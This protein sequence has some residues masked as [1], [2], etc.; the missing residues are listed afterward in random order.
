MQIRKS[1]P[2]DNGAAKDLVRISL[3]IFG[4][5]ADFDNLDKAIGLLGT[6]DSENSIELVAVLDGVVVGCLAIQRITPQCAR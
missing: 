4:I 6:I 2:S 3:A 1:T 5:E